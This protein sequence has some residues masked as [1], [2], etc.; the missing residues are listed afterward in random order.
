MSNLSRI[1]E[2]QRAAREAETL[3]AL[4][5]I[6]AP[7]S[8]SDSNGID[9]LPGAEPS[10]EEGHEGAVTIIGGTNY[11]SMSLQS[12]LSSTNPDIPLYAGKGRG[13]EAEAVEWGAEIVMPPEYLLEQKLTPGRKQAV[14]VEAV[15]T[16]DLTSTIVLVGTGGRVKAAESWLKR[17]NW[18]RR[19]ERIL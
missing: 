14:E 13:A 3:A 9:S 10:P 7:S 5:E 16:K 18:P 12:R 8:A 17:A 11:D 19:V 2:Q 4:E 15:L 1:R 6:A